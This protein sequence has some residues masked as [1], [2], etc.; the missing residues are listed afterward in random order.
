MFLTICE[1]RDKLQKYLAKYNVQS[2]VYY[3]TPLHLHGASKSLGYQSDFP[4]AEKVCK[5]VLAL[6][7]HQYLSEKQIYFV[8]NKINAFYN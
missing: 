3:G 1:Q 8:A 4:I 6:P 5:K 2:L 7:H